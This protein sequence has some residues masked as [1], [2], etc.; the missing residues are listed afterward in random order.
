MVAEQTRIDAVLEESFNTIPQLIRLHAAACP[1]RCALVQDGAALTYAELDALMDRVA[2]ALQRDGVRPGQAIA[3]CAANSIA[4][5]AAFLGSLRAGV[6]VAPLAPSSSAQSLAHMAADAGARLLFL[7]QAAA[8]ALEPLRGAMQAATV[9]LDDGAFAPGFA[10]WLAAPGAAPTAVDIRP[11]WPFNIIYSSGTTGAP[12]GIVQPHSMRWTHMQRGRING[13]GPDAVTLISTPLYSNTTLVSFFPTLG[14]GG[15]VVLMAK[16]DAGAYLALAKQHRVTHTMLVPVQYQRIMARPDFERH[17]LSS[18][19]MKFCTSAPFSAAL[20]ADILRR[21]PG[22]LIEYY[23]MT[24][25]G[26]TC[27]LA[28]HEHPDKLHTVGQPAPGHDIRLID[29][30]GREVGPGELG[31]VVGH[32]PAMMAGYHNQPEKTAEAEWHDP[33]GK[34]F[35]RTGDIGRFDADGFLT[36]MDRKKD[37]IISGGFN[38]Y[39]SDLESV[40]Q[41]H[42]DVAEAAVVGV[43]SV[44]WGETPVAFVVRKPGASIAAEQ[45]LDWANQRLGKTQRLAAVELA[46]ALPRSAIGKVLRRELR[47][48]FSSVRQVA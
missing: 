38:I 7:D 6:A 12:K 46:A 45:L 29:D 34:R 13:Y 19:R 20:K 33:S 30:A 9:A 25:G 47:D 28:A 17:D 27:V 3:I 41:Q 48:Q 18:F 23:G 4:Y 36:L 24:E 21:W 2:A 35:I 26:G 16:F 8:Q 10:Q 5:A 42:P 14:L 40:L 11:D 1:G 43:P 44:R 31:E 37:M 22:G 39:P 15:T 32:S